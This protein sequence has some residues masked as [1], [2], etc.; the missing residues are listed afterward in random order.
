MTM[1]NNEK[2]LLNMNKEN[3]LEKVSRSRDKEKENIKTRLG[4][5]TIEQRRVENLK[6][7]HRIGDWNLGQKKAL[8]EYDQD[9]YDKE[10]DAIEY[11]ALR[12]KKA[13]GQIDDVSEMNMDI[14]RMNYQET[15]EIQNRID[16]ELYNLGGIMEDGEG[17]EDDYDLDYGDI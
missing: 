13:M 8:F 14:F 11:E 12:E 9:Q 5:L 1:M 3:I 6:K 7:K 17:D 10:R 15:E 16:R 4:E 2:R